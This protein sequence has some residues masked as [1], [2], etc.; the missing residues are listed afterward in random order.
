ML[1]PPA[2]FDVAA[3]Q[4]PEAVYFCKVQQ[5]HSW[6]LPPCWEPKKAQVLPD[7][8]Q[9]CRSRKGDEKWR[10]QLGLH[11]LNFSFKDTVFNSQKWTRSARMARR[12][13]PI[14]LTAIGRD[15]TPKHHT[16]KSMKLCPQQD[17]WLKKGRA[18]VRKFFLT[19]EYNS[20]NLLDFFFWMISN[21]RFLAIAMFSNTKHGWIFSAINW[22]KIY[23]FHFKGQHLKQNTKPVKSPNSNSQPWIHGTF[24]CS[25]TQ[26][27]EYLSPEAS[28]LH[29]V[30]WVPAISAV[31]F[32][33]VVLWS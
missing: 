13:I 31:N 19:S 7:F 2:G 29:D 27:F 3:S 5:L 23:I 8:S 30:L 17:C 21:F 33:E 32:L 1:S 12:L 15:D 24:P 10:A 6:M 4:P 16:Q 18:T 14:H 9:C 22:K 11:S 25:T 28:K 26:G 20:E